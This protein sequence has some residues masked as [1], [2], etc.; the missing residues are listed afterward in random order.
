VIRLSGL[1]LCALVVAASAF[2]AD[3]AAPPTGAQLAAKTK[4][5]HPISGARFGTDENRPRT[6]AVCGAAGVLFWKADM[7]IDCD[8]Q[9]TTH[10]NIGADAAFQ[11]GTALSPGGKALAA[12][13]TPYVVIPQR[14][15]SFD[16]GRY[17]IK[18][19]AVAA[20][21]YNG[22]VAFAVFGDT[23]PKE[24]LGEASYRVA[25]MLGIDPDPSTGGTGSGVTYIVF[26]NT[27]VK[28]ARSA[29]SIAMA[30]RAAA[31]R[32]IGTN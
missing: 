12:E 32:F 23:G 7:D 31:A 1:G 5:C 9:V 11:P 26:K 15:A 20:I 19:G 16:Y 10:C 6:I 29:A 4:T 18:L 22:K 3:A 13:T 28:D 30:G 8:G 2:A 21:V 27:R 14:S 24:I 25:K 17:G